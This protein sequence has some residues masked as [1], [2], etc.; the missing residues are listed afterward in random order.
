VWIIS[1][2][3]PIVAHDE[4]CF[5]LV[6]FVGGLGFHRNFRGGLLTIISV[7]VLIRTI[8]QSLLIA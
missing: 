3:T 4:Q 1:N 7:Q 2:D 8:D 5:F 6:G